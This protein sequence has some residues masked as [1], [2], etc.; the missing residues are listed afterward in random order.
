MATET[1]SLAITPDQGTRWRWIAAG[2]LA[3]GTAD[4]AFAWSF[5]AAKAGVSMQRILQ[6]ISRGLLGKSSFDGGV[7]TAALGAL[8]HYAIIAAMIAT[9]YAAS[10]RL[11]VLARS[12][13]TFGSLYGLAL[14]AVMTYVVVPLS[15]AGG[16]SDDPLWT[17]MSIGVHVLIGIACAWCAHRIRR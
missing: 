9:Y 14:Y 6:S 7:A 13:V 5:W 17:G 8:L 10:R 15:R 3:A 16:V 4:L 11:P 2:T 1:A 12:W